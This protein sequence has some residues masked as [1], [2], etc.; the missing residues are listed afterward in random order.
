[1]TF[2]TVKN[3]LSKIWQSKPHTADKLRTYLKQ[4]ID[5]GMA[6]KLVQVK[7]NPARLDGPL[8]VLMQV[9]KNDRKEK[10][11]FSTADFNEIPS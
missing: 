7:E 1:M 2:E 9:Y 6:M 10:E 5:W 3:I 4:M 11:N 8:G